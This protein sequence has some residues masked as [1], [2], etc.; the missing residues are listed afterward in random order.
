MELSCRVT[1]R[2][3]VL[4][5]TLIGNIGLAFVRLTRIPGDSPPWTSSH[6]HGHPCASFCLLSKGKYSGLE[7][8]TLGVLYKTSLPKY[9]AFSDDRHV[10]RPFLITITPL[11]DLRTQM[12]MKSPRPPDAREYL[13]SC[14]PVPGAVREKDNL[15]RSSKPSQIIY[16]PGIILGATRSR[17]RRMKLVR[18]NAP[19]VI[20]HVGLSRIVGQHRLPTRAP[21]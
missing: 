13:C 17:P 5:K 7:K 15:R 6:P 21:G 20:S 1:Q 9:D 4:F 18:R 19:P 3:S 12:S 14:R 2:P 10:K 8:V 11:H 16:Y